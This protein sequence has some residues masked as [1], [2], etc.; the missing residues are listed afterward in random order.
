M[1]VNRRTTLKLG[2]GT[3]LLPLLGGACTAAGEK[4]VEHRRGARGSTRCRPLPLSAVR[5]TGGPLRHAQRLNGRYL[6]A[7]EPDRMLSYYRQRAGLAPRA[8]PYGGW[9][10]GGR[11]LTGHIC[12]HYLSAVSIMW[13]AT[14]EARYRQRA[15]YIVRELKLVQDAHGDGFLGALEGL[16]EAFARLARGEIESQSFD[17]NGLWSP[18]Y[19]LHKTY[20][21][22]R[23]AY[24]YTGNRTALEIEIRFA[25]WAGHILAAL[26]ERQL[27][28]MMN[29]EFGG[30]NEI[31]VDLYED[32]GD[33]RW[34]DLSCKFEHDDFL[35]PLRRHRDN[36][37]GKHAN[38]AVP[39]L[40]G[41]ADRYAASG[42]AADLMAA[43]FFWDTVVRRHTFATGGHGKDEYFGPP[44]KLSARVDGRTA[45]TCNVYNMLKLTRRLFAISP[46]VRFADFHER[47][48][49]NHI[50]GSMDP[51]DG[52]TCYMVPVGRGVQHEYQAMFESFTCCVGSGMESHALHGDGIYYEEGDDRLY[53]NLYVP[54]TA[55]WSRAGVA[56][57]METDFPL[58]EAASL[59]VNMRA[60]R[61]LTL[62]L[63]RPEWTGERF[64]VRINGREVP[65]AGAPAE[66][67][68]DSRSQYPK[69]AAAGSRFLD[70]TR[71]WRDGDVVQIALPKSLRLE[72]TPD[73]PRRA[74]ILWGPLVMA[75]DLGPER[76]RSDSE[77]HE[78][79]AP[80]PPAPVLVAAD[81]PAET[82]L[83]PVDA[84]TGRFR[85][86]GVS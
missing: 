5:V 13:A 56:L 78:A 41:S 30:M 9:D 53:V 80:A 50:L 33:A 28:H 48:L 72:P 58:G 83:K 86:A 45:E 19:T 14:G 57:T 23:D 68:R 44:G 62:S 31:M 73:N 6:M 27:E 42:R 36:L 63:R 47:A 2:I 16:R 32:T 61:R 54:S 55:E 84:A 12:G 10:G 64:A 75:G 79:V 46:D 34:L 29:T 4:V 37:N 85:T 66:E 59:R 15:D 70:L 76:R 20:A 1:T 38:T 52:R 39:K 18:W 65:L 77:E 60:P 40:I 26:D 8:E 74:A 24:R 43:A 51:E 17:L 69:S 22:L 82:W 81:R 25:E 35:Q 21:G 7:L 67:W 71:E 49:F 11:N 3:G